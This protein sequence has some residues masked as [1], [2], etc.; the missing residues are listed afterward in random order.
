M[1]KTVFV[2]SKEK[3]A[4]KKFGLCTEKKSLALQN[5]V[6]SQWRVFSH[7]CDSSVFCLV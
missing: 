6:A 7:L 5:F 1:D 3:A 4:E 2:S